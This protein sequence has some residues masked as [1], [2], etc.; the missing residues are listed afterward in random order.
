[1]YCK[2]IP[3]KPTALYDVLLLTELDRKMPEVTTLDVTQAWR[4]S[5]FP[6]FPS[7]ISLWSTHA[8]GLARE[9]WYCGCFSCLKDES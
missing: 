2:A 6:G 7:R 4:T 3:S 8:P 5:A 1:M 9:V